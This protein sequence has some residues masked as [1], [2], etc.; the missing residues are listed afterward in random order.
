VK[1]YKFEVTL[2]VPDNSDI[3]DAI[4]TQ[5]INRGAFMTKRV[6]LEVGVEEIENEENKEEVSS[7]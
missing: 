4:L 3:N 6:I 1:E 7:S 5:I 2:Q